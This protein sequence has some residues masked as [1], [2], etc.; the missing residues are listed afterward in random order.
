MRNIAWHA[1]YFHGT[2]HATPPAQTEII[3]APTENE[4]AEVAI[5]HMGN[6]K[7]V[8]IAAPRWEPEQDLVIL[9]IDGRCAIRP[10]SA[11]DAATR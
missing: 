4:A 7:R 1:F 5:A 11:V 6:C 10:A 2:D 3:E 9:S 8:D